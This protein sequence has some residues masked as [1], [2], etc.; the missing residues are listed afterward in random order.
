MTEG[1]PWILSPGQVGNSVICLTVSQ[2]SSDFLAP[3]T[4]GLSSFS[5]S[6]FYNGKFCFSQVLSTIN[7]C[8][9][10]LSSH[11]SSTAA[12]MWPPRGAHVPAA[13]CRQPVL[14]SV[15]QTEK[16]GAP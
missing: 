9:C 3:L 1:H 14:V 5:L 13:S 11:N 2:K 15:M 7:Y 10:S 12:G 16:Q 8:L 6:L 4:G